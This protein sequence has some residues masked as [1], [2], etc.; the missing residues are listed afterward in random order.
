[1]RKSWSVPYFFW[2]IAVALAGLLFGFDTAVN[3]GADQPLQALWKTSDLLH[4]AF[5]MSSALW[6]TVVGALYGS[7]PCDKYGRKLTLIATGIL[8][9]ASA[10]GSAIAPDPYSFS[11]LRFIGGLGRLYLI[12]QILKNCTI[13]IRMWR[14]IRLIP[15]VRRPASRAQRH[16]IYQGPWGLQPEWNR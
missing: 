4:G 12:Y 14:P 16:C 1:M 15:P 5:I 10:L 2:S 11:I 13:K 9:L 7:V 3:S 6:G 8:F